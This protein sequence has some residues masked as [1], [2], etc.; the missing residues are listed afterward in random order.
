MGVDVG[1]GVGVGVGVGGAGAFEFGEVRIG[2]KRT[3][4]KLKSSLKS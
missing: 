4:P 1:S 2:W 3:V